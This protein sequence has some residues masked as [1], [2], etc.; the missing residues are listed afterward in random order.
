MHP[1]RSENG[2]KMTEKMIELAKNQPRKNEGPL[3]L[4]EYVFR[5]LKCQS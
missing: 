1:Q 2:E 3:S 5:Y 4:G